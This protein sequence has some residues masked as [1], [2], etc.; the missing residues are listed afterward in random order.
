MR[1]AA[2]VGTLGT[3]LLYRP[4]TRTHANAPYVASVPSVPNAASLAGAAHGEYEKL[5]AAIRTCCA[6]RGDTDRNR[7]GLIA[8]AADYDIDQQIDL[9]EHFNEQAAIWRRV[10]GAAS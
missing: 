6:P 9:T 8:E 4:Y 2:E 7:D 5:I 3:L 1:R 10:T